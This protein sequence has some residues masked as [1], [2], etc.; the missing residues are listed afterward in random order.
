[1]G[2]VSYLDAIL[3]LLHTSTLEDRVIY[4]L[5]VIQYTS[6][7]WL[8]LHYIAFLQDLARQGSPPVVLLDC[9]RFLSKSSLK[10]HD[11]FTGPINKKK[12]LQLKHAYE[13]GKRPLKGRHASR[14]ASVEDAGN[15]LMLWLG[16]LP[17]PIMAME[18]VWKIASKAHGMDESALYGV[19]KSSILETEP[20]ILEAMYP[21]CEMLHHMYL[22]QE[23]RASSLVY[24][25]NLFCAPLLGTREEH[26]LMGGD[27]DALLQQTCGLLIR[28][29][30]GLFTQPS[31][32]A[33]GG[34]VTVPKSTPQDD[35]MHLFSHEDT[36]DDAVDSMICSTFDTILSELLDDVEEAEERTSPLKKHKMNDTSEQQMHFDFK[37]Q[38]NFDGILLSES[39]TS[40]CDATAIHL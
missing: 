4:T 19:I 1:M 22:N 16:S 3:L 23:D 36:F 10:D 15:L 25:S 38:M 28:E 24:L 11:L 26:G 13:E 21:L 35:D 6:T 17:E 39:P 2:V 29:Y 30:R 32:L 20:F 34:Q 37:N 5:Y 7:C 40:V 33:C 12:L 27:Y 18:H 31:V 9:L 14:R 8:T